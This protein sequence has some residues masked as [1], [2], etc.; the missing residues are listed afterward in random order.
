MSFNIQHSTHLYAKTNVQ[1]LLKI[2]NPNPILECEQ[3]D[4]VFVYFLESMVP[5][6][7]KLV[8]STSQR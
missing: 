1:N 3:A 5:T 8:S 2:E 6:S 4:F 7:T